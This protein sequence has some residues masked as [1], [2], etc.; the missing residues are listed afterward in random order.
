MNI[1]VKKRNPHFLSVYSIAGSHGEINL[2]Y[3][4]QK[5][6]HFQTDEAF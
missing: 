1:R 6:W 5:T 4:V 3:F 2:K